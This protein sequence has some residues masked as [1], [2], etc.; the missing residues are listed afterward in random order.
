MAAFDSHGVVV[1]R[2]STG[3]IHRPNYGSSE[4]YAENHGDVA[5]RTSDW[6]LSPNLKTAIEANFVP[7]RVCFSQTS[8]GG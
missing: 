8:Q 3:T 2:E 6:E 1:A 4:S 7:C 5:L